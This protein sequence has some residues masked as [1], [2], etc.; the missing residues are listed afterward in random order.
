ME[1]PELTTALLYAQRVAAITCT[2]VGADP[3]WR[4]QLLDD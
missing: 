3:P 1:S 4:S 2:R